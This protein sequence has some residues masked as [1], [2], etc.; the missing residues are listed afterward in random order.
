M[1]WTFTLFLRW[2]FSFGKNVRNF[3]QLNTTQSTNVWNF[4]VLN[5]TQWAVF[6]FHVVVLIFSI[7]Y[8]TTNVLNVFNPALML[9]DFDMR[10]SLFFWW[11]PNENRVY[12]VINAYHIT[13]HIKDNIFDHISVIDHG[14]TLKRASSFSVSWIKH[15]IHVSERRKKFKLIDCEGQKIEKDE[16]KWRW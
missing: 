14:Y 8:Y 15:N 7:T 12:H 3:F 6:L 11:S 5:S 10:I 13:S 16:D 4:A 2:L 9:V 1:T